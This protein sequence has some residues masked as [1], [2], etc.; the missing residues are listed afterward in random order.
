MEGA[1]ATVGTTF[2]T[3]VV[4]MY[5][6]LSTAPENWNKAGSRV[7]E[8]QSKP[9]GATYMTSE[10]ISDYLAG[11]TPAP[12]EYRRGAEARKLTKAQR[13]A[14]EN[15]ESMLER[16]KERD[17]AGPSFVG[18]ALKVGER[19]W[20]GAFST[21]TGALDTVAGAFKSRPAPTEIAPPT[22]AVSVIE[23]GSGSVIVANPAAAEEVKGTPKVLNMLEKIAGKVINNSLA[24][25]VKDAF[26][27]GRR[28]LL[29][30]DEY[31]YS[32]IKVRVVASVKDRKALEFTRV[33]SVDE[34]AED[35]ISQLNVRNPELAERLTLALKVYNESQTTGAI[36]REKYRFFKLLDGDFSFSGI[37]TAAMQGIVE[38]GWKK[39]FLEYYKF[40]LP[41]MLGMAIPISLVTYL[42]TKLYFASRIL[43]ASKTLASG[44]LRSRGAIQAPEAYSDALADAF[45]TRNPANEAALRSYVREEKM[46]QHIMDM[47]STLLSHIRTVQ[48]PALQEAAD[49]VHVIKDIVE[50]VV[51]E[52]I[53]RRPSRSSDHARSLR[54]RSE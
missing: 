2:G 41:L 33:Q 4:P 12:M 14:I 18:R 54:D 24:D 49:P 52:K 30:P 46:V 15:R 43:N 20:T 1:L 45:D 8:F 26:K 36:L 27:E 48:G 5:A 7:R 22:S 42:G 19:A 38:I 25:T 9:Y 39:V 37:T 50:Q 21:V 29:G 51:N 32:N 53:S 3:G 11:F 16:Q 23:L 47:N 28:N 35:L 34:A 13:M 17:R 40:W 44:A 6:D 31:E 10:E